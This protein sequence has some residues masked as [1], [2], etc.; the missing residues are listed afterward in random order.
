MYVSPGHTRNGI[1]TGTSAKGNINYEGENNSDDVQHRV[2]LEHR[3]K[4]PQMRE[5]CQGERYASGAACQG[6]IALPVSLKAH[7]EQF[8][9]N[10]LEAFT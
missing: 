8:M 5:R 2:V 6:H 7:E 4:L 9:K 3:G 10:Y 1:N